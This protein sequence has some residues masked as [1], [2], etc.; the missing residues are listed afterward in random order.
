MEDNF[1]YKW[2]VGITLIYSNN[3][4]IYYFY[5]IIF[6]FEDTRGNKFLD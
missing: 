5:S 1:F 3:E 2:M 6:Y 4:Q